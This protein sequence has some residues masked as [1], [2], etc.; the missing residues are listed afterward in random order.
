[1][2]TFAGPSKEQQLTIHERFSEAAQGYLYG[3][4]LSWF[5]PFLQFCKDM[6]HIR[7]GGL[8]VGLL[9]FFLMFWVGFFVTF[10]HY[11]VTYIFTPSSKVLLILF[12]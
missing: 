4:C 9:V 5:I 2:L 7:T 12:S 3:A 11:H 6:G 8:G 10:K 1:M